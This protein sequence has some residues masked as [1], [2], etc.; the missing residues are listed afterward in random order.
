MMKIYGNM[1]P[2]ILIITLSKLTYLDT[3]ASMIIHIF[4]NIPHHYH[5]FI[6]FFVNNCGNEFKHRALIQS[7]NDPLTDNNNINLL[8][9]LG[10]TAA[11]YSNNSQLLSLMKQEAKESEFIF[12]SL[13]NRKLWLELLFSGFLKRSSWVSWGADIYQYVLKKQT[14]KQV[15]AKTI[16]SLACKKMHYVKSLNPGDGKLITQ[17][18]GRKKVE[19]LPYPLVGVKQPEHLGIEAS[20]NQKILLGNS[21][22]K[23]NNH[24]ELLDSIK[25]LA[26][27][28]ISVY[29]PLNYAGTPD[30]IDEVVEYGQTLFGDK[31]KPTFEMLSKE[32]YD[33][34]LASIDVTVFAHDRQQGLYVA[35]YMMLH[36]KKLFLKASTSTFTN[37]K[38]YGFDVFSLENLASIQYQELKQINYT[39]QLKNQNTLINNFTE[40]A[41][42]K[43]WHAFFQK[44]THKK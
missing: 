43:K 31:F 26:A 6:S 8:G 19:T 10:C 24:F 12:H 20:A 13:T 27:D 25:H 40:K 2:R 32:E 33:Q 35:Y 3:I 11:T 28:D 16:H 18:L 15:I 1:C 44:L 36:G 34:L 5:N 22:A 29:M 30:Y 21:A 17:I 41:L 7:S 42:A 23:S 9:D 38:S 14:L 4:E 37:F 39:S